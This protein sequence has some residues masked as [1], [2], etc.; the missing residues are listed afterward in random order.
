MLKRGCNILL[1]TLAVSIIFPVLYPFVFS[2]IEDGF[3]PVLTEIFPNFFSPFYVLR[4]LGRL[5]E[6]ILKLKLLSGIVTVFILNFIPPI[7]SF[8]RYMDIAQKT[9]GLYRI[10]DVYFRHILNTL[11]YDTAASLFATLIFACI[12]K[13]DFTN[14]RFALFISGQMEFYTVFTD[15][16]GTAWGFFVFAMAALLSRI[17]SARPALVR[18]RAKWI[19]SFNDR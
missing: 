1:G 16:F 8:D 11:P 5:N 12:L 14:E 17:L 15:K 3:Y 9:N 13:I 7:Y 10:K 18:Y 4:N 6:A 19:C 2:L